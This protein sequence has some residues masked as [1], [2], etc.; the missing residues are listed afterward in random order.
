[1][2]DQIRA[3]EETNAWGWQMWDPWNA[4]DPRKAFEKP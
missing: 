3:A 4:Y 1:V 2:I